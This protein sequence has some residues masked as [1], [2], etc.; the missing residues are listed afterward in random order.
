MD[1]INPLVQAY[2]EK[3]TSAEDNLLKEVAA[4][5]Y[6]NHPKS[7]M[8]SGLV[9]G[10]FLEMISNMIQPKR[11]LEIGTLTGYSALCLAKG[12]HT[13][14]LLHT[15]E[16]REGD[17]TTAKNYF[18]RSIYQ[19]K[20]RL[21]IGD[22]LTIIEE[23]NETWDLVFIDADKENYI[24]YFDLV[25]PKIRPGGF[26]LADNVLFHGQVLEDPI[27]GKNAKAIQAFND[28]V[29]ARTDVAKMLLPLRDGIY[30]IRK[31]H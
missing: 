9:Q 31:L 14:G 20:I 12:L 11:V 25:I 26:I 27:K 21:H 17:A 8:L 24:H 30:L 13:D 28:Y 5:T 10:S 1:L 7:H 29:L 23:L 6:A 2:A 19:Q 4:F 16:L 18:D 22:A 15:I 3:Y